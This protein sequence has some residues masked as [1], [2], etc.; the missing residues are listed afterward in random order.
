MKLIVLSAPKGAG[1]TEAVQHLKNT[2]NHLTWVETRCKDKLYE[3]TA[4]MFGLSM[5][6]FMELYENRD[7]KESPL[8]EFQVGLAAVNAL[9][10]VLPDVD[11]DYNP[12][13]KKFMLS[14]RSAMIYVSEVVCK[15]TFGKDYFG[16][17][18]AKRMASVSGAG[19]IF[20]DD[21]AFGTWDE[22]EA[23]GKLVGA[24]N[25]MVVRVHGRGEFDGSDSRQYLEDVPS[26][27]KELDIWND[28]T[29]REFLD[30]VAKE[31]GEWL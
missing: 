1:K 30:A 2:F 3:L 15:P 11:Y 6:R 25:V 24:F 21:S 18:R 17:E 16:V 29:E 31:V 7:L 23:A 28:K 20:I 13:T 26:G 27:V 5:R 8:E 14:I 9:L 4:R 19:A 22:I 10:D 12:I